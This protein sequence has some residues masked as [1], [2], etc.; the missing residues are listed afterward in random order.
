M[1]HPRWGAARTCHLRQ[2]P[3]QSWETLVITPP[4]CKNGTYPYPFHHGDYCPLHPECKLEHSVK[5]LGQWKFAPGI[6]L[7]KKLKANGQTIWMI[8]CVGCGNRKI[9]GQHESNILQ[10]RGYQIAFVIDWTGTPDDV[11]SIKGCRRRDIEIQHWMPQAIL[12]KE[13]ENWPKSALCVE[14]HQQFH[15]L[16]W[17]G[18]FLGKRKGA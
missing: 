16:V 10:K 9:I 6:Q 1:Q 4:E 12:G 13:A 2:L 14:H 7:G 11:C 18:P 8:Q 3:T 15:A 5:V 17:P